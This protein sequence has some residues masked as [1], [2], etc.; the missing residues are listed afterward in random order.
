MRAAGFSFKALTQADGA[1][2]TIAGGTSRAVT[3]TGI[4]NPFVPP[5]RG[6]RG[7]RRRCGRQG[8]TDEAT[9]GSMADRGSLPAWHDAPEQDFEARQS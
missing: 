1:A 7:R 2:V 9:A 4:R 3:R 6:V 8:R 5:I